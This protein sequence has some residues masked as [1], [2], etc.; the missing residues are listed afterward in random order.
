MA[1]ESEAE[2]AKLLLS[3][4]KTEYDFWK[5]AFPLLYNGTVEE[6]AARAPGY[7]M[8]RQFI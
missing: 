5:D 2:F 7:C 3:G 1:H 4:Y 8:M 6:V